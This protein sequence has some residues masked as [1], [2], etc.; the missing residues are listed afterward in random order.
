MKR[1]DFTLRPRR[2]DVLTAARAVFEAFC[3]DH[4]LD[5]M[6]KVVVRDGELHSL[7]WWGARDVGIRHEEESQWRSTP[8]DDV[9]VLQGTTVSFGPRPVALELS[10][11]GHTDMV[12]AVARAPDEA[13]L[14]RT[15]EVAARAFT[16]MEPAEYE[17]HQLLYAVGFLPAD[18]FGT[19]FQSLEQWRFHPVSLVGHDEPS[20]LAP[21]LLRL[22]AA[23]PGETRASLLGLR[24][25]LHARCGNRDDALRCAVLAVERDPTRDDL[26]MLG[27]VLLARA[28]RSAEALAQLPLRAPTTENTLAAAVDVH[29]LTGDLHGAVA[30][31]DAYTGY[32]PALEQRGLAAVALLYRAG[33]AAESDARL[34]EVVRSAP[35]MC[36]SFAARGM[37]RWR[38]FF[39]ANWAAPGFWVAAWERMRPHFRRAP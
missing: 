26:W 15:R 14:Q 32:S 25:L 6:H 11:A 8:G 21:W 2:T 39:P 19:A 5:L 33:R 36:A 22:T 27:A 10:A 30:L 12:Y 31:L 13:T 20:A 18:V 9:L 38:Q 37:D 29:V 28:G 1:L 4:G 34:L 35:D 24:A 16:G 3:P 23:D 7:W 17:A